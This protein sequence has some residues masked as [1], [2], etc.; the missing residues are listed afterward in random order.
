MHPPRRTWTTFWC[1]NRSTR[2]LGE[3]QGRFGS[4]RE[5]PKSAQGPPK[6]AKAIFVAPLGFDPLGGRRDAGALWPWD[7]CYIFIQN[8]GFRVGGVAFSPI[9]QTLRFAPPQESFALS[10]HAEHAGTAKGSYCM[11]F[12]MQRSGLTRLRGKRAADFG[13]LAPPKGSKILV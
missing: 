10:L 4:S 11:C 9:R 1:K 13:A 12:A 5:R 6:A 2:R 8:C 3:V 7:F